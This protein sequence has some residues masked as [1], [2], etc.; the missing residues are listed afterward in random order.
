MTAIMAS[1]YNEKASDLHIDK[2]PLPIKQTK[3]EMPVMTL[4]A[5]ISAS[6]VISEMKQ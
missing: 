5:K 3:P 6:I 1:S 4:H 2:F